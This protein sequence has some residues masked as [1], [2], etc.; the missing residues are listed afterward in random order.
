M[1]TRFSSLL[2]TMLAVACAAAAT[3]WAG[4]TP[5]G[6]AFTYQGQLQESG[7][8]ASGLYDF[9]VCLFD[10]PSEAASLVCAPDF[11]D[12]PVDNGLFT[13][14]LDFGAASFAGQTRYLELRLRP[15]G[16]G[17]AY[18]SLTPRQPIRPAPEALHAAS[19]PWSGL[20]E[21][22]AGFSVWLSNESLG[23]VTAVTAGTGLSGGTITGSGA[24]GIADGGVGAQQINPTQVQSR[25][26]G[27]CPL[28]SYLRGIN[29][30]GSVLCSDLPGVTTLTTVDDPAANN[31]GSYTSIAIGSDG[32]PVISYRNNTAGALKVAKCTNAAC[33]GSA[34]IT[35]VDNPANSVG[36]YTSIAIGSDGLPVI[37][38]HDQSAGALKVAKCAN[39]ACTGSA[40]ITIVDNPANNVGLYTSIAIGSDSLPVISYRDQSAGALKVAKCA[41]AACTGG[42]NITT[43]DNPANSVGEY[44]S[45]AIGSDGLPVISYYDNSAGALKVAKCANAACTGS[46][47]I[48]VV[49]NPANDVGRYTSIAI[50]NDGLPVISYR[51]QLAGTLKVAKCT[52]AACTGSATIEIVDN[53]A[54]VGAF[55]SIAIGSDGLP[56]ISYFDGSASA[57]KVAKCAN[58]ACTSGATITTVDSTFGVGYH[59]SI[60]IGSDGLPVISHNNSDDGTLKVAKCGTRSCQ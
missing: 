37:S 48:T 17:D 25:V 32:L 45:I 8:P 22:P 49:D 15:G 2:V 40:T 3:A 47:T 44:T 35:T 20:S 4:V 23:T 27:T 41:N 53:S 29:A 46:A 5:L 34:T 10:S 31:V 54:I 60:V 52:N 42:A 50:G 51:D 30:D 55:T 21:V 19:A 28:G 13:L 58:A 12:V 36:E 38:Y 24:I 26:A 59:T 7:Q 18:T 33:T 56:V 16:S 14:T 11:E 9:Q 1:K 43:V 39:V 6:T 57:L